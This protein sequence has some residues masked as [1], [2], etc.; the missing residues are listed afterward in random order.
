MNKLIVALIASAFAMTAAAQGVGQTPKDKTKQ[1]EVDAATKMGTTSTATQEAEKKGVADAKAAKG[2]AKDL[3][4]K[5]DKSKA[6]QAR[7]RR[8]P[9][10]LP[11]AAGLPV[12]SLT[13]TR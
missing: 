7:P 10:A 8:R 5:S 2:T 9:K 3:P 6:V 12:H 1:S 13:R 11:P 4:T